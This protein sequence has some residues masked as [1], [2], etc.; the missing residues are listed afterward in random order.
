MVA[1][2]PLVLRLSLIPASSPIAFAAASTLDEIAVGGG[3]GVEADAD[4]DEDDDTA[5]VVV[6]DKEAKE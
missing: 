2:P 6:V 5:G 4:D 1:H 3:V